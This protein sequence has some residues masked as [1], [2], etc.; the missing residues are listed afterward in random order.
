MLEV[1]TVCPVSD[2]TEKSWLLMAPSWVVGES[3]FC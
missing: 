3:K 2:W 1:L